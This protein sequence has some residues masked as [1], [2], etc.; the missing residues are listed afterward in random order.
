MG[1]RHV[2]FFFDAQGTAEIIA[3]PRAAL[4]R[5]GEEGGGG[6]GEGGRRGEEERRRGEEEERCVSD[7]ET[8]C[9]RLTFDLD[10]H[11]R[12]FGSK[13]LSVVEF[14]GGETLVGTAVTRRHA[15]ETHC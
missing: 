2:G 11:R 9:L 5:V 6:G 4:F 8:P 10:D 7:Q 12:A 1:N 13:H 15:A 14:V 3:L